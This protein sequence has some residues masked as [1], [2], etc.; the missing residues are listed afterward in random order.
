KDYQLPDTMITCGSVPHSWLFR[1]GY[2]VIHHCGFGTAS[3]AMIYGIPSIPVP[4]VLDQIGFAKQLEA[5]KVSTKLLSSSKLS[6]SLIIVAIHEL[7]S[8]Y[9]ELFDNVQKLSFKLQDEK[10]LE[11]AVHLI[12][13][14]I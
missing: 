12:E 11:K 14:A 13:K 2:A 9:D 4:H 7:D 8:N 3:A 6:E 5:L 1:Q 10:G